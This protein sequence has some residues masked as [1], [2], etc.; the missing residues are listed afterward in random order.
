[1]PPRHAKPLP[2]LRSWDRRCRANRFTSEV[3]L[4][5]FGLLLV[6]IGATAGPAGAQVVGRAHASRPD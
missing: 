3:A 6:G 1:M 2:T 5:A 4:A